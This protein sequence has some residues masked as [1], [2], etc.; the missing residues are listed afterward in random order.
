MA[1]YNIAIIYANR[2]DIDLAIKWYTKAIEV[3][4]RYHKAYN[5]LGNIYKDRN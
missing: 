5:N 1:Y 2:K 4:P 3:N